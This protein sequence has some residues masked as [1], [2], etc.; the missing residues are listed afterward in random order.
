MSVKT[1]ISKGYDKIARKLGNVVD[2]FRA[3]DYSLTGV[4]HPRNWLF[5]KNLSVTKSENYSSNVTMGLNQFLGYI[6]FLDLVQGDVLH[7]GTKTYFV[8]EIKD[9]E[10]PTIIQCFNIFD[11][12]KR[13]WN[14]TT[15]TFDD[16]IICNE[17]P[18]NIQIKGSSSDNQNQST[19]NPDYT[20]NWSIETWLPNGL[21][22]INDELVLD[23]GHKA[24]V[25]NV[26]YH[27]GGLTID[28][29]EIKNNSG[30]N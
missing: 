9:I 22:N 3:S 1:K 8:G 28:C 11:C 13:V 24:Q 15:R 20:L 10:P 2:V 27:N 30:N 12:Y 7:D 26:F 5:T 6:D 19:G 17:V 21:I 23:T 4:I 29:K 18:C 14:T 25:T 16:Q